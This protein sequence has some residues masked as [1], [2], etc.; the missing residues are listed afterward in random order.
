MS[1]LTASAF[2]SLVVLLDQSE[3]ALKDELGFLLLSHYHFNISRTSPPTP[4][5]LHVQSTF[6]MGVRGL[7]KHL[8][9]YAEWKALGN[10]AEG[11]SG[12]P[13]HEGRNVV[14]DGPSL[15]FFIYRRLLTHNLNGS[16][17]LDSIPS[18]SMLG[19]AAVAFLKQLQSC[20]LIM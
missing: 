15:A 8:L 14:I 17:V 7:T 20:G 18:Y 11:Q 16:N 4:S 19:R 1:E 5:S 12:S 6:I 13:C 2:P 3:T 10:P 9:P